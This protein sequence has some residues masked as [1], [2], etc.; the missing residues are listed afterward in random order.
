MAALGRPDV[1]VTT[2][3][4]NSFLD[5]H[6]NVPEFTPGTGLFSSFWPHKN[7]DT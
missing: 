4:Q 6:A 7:A 3:C 2:A 1:Q 5:P